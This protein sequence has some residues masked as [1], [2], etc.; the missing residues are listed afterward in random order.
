M[1]TI[2][3]KTPEV[4]L[5][6]RLTI[7]SDIIIIIS[8]EWKPA[9]LSAGSSFY[10][11]DVKKIVEK[12]LEGKLTLIK[13]DSIESIPGHDPLVFTQFPQVAEGIVKIR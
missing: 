2:P 7:W 10:K 5:N 13:G 1:H 12:N 4:R 9:D 8:F 3:F 11:D 6:R